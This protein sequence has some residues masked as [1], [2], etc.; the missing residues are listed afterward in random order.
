M[1]PMALTDHKNGGTN[2]NGQSMTA[3][4]KV[5][6]MFTGKTGIANEFLQDGDTYVTWDDG[7]FGQPKWYNLEPI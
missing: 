6:C 2:R 1:H 4:D 5:R 3:G 7:T